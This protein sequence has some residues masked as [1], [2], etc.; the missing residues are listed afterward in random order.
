MQ[1]STQVAMRCRVL[2]HEIQA[3]AI[4]ADGRFEVAQLLLSSSQ[5]NVRK[6][7]LRPQFDSARVADARLLQPAL[8]TQCMSVIEMGI[9]ILGQ[10]S[11]RHF[12][13]L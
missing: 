10:Q 4:A 9:G 2:R 5:M 3:A 6:S 8:P 11:R 1:S 13:R 12:E 7:E